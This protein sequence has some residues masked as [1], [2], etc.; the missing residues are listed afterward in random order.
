MTA[1][2]IAGFILHKIGIYT[3]HSGMTATEILVQILQIAPVEFPLVWLL[4]LANK[5]IHQQTRLYEEYLH[6]W[7][8]SR[9]F[10]GMN[11]I[12]DEV[13]DYDSTSPASR[14][15]SEFLLACTLNPSSTLEKRHSTDSPMHAAADCASSLFPKKNATRSAST[16]SPIIPTDDGSSG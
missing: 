6:K 15:F 10:E 12:A 11:R 3:L 16:P 9:T 2:V 5:N 8:V 13:S 4:L 1:M 7:A 14:L